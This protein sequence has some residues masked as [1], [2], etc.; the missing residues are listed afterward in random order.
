MGGHSCLILDNLAMK[1]KGMAKE[2]Y[3][4]G[5]YVLVELAPNEKYVVTILEVHDGHYDVLEYSAGEVYGE[6]YMEEDNHRLIGK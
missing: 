2:K 4:A 5:D 1:G 3:T 6:L